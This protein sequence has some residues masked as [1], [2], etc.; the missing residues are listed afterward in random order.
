MCQCLHFRLRK[1]YRRLLHAILLLLF[2]VADWSVTTAVPDM[3][4]LVQ[5]LAVLAIASLLLSASA[6]TTGLIP[7]SKKKGQQIHIALTAL[8]TDCSSSDTLTTVATPAAAWSP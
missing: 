8:L 1:C 6:Q 3:A 2:T 7:T 5:L 4:R